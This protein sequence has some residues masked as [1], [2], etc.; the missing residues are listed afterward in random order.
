[1]IYYTYNI[2]NCKSIRGI[3]ATVVIV[4][5]CKRALSKVNCFIKR[6]S[7]VLITFIPLPMYNWQYAKSYKKKLLIRINYRSLFLQQQIITN[8]NRIK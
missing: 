6:K 8:L 2:L 3:I 5:K 7:L 1:M 4:N